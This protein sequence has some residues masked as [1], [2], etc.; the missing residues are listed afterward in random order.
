MAGLGYDCPLCGARA[1][2]SRSESEGATVEFSMRCPAGCRWKYDE[3][4]GSAEETIGIV[5]V[6]RNWTDV[7]SPEER[8]LRKTVL[9]AAI[10][11]EQAYRRRVPLPPAD[12]KPPQ[13]ES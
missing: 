8:R 10:A 5:T 7:D 12:V 9:D 2:M 13:L 3:F 4:A 6:Y 11:L 1:D